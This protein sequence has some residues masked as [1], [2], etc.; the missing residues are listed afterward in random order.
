MSGIEV[1]FPA[2]GVSRRL[3]VTVGHALDG[4]AHVAECTCCSSVAFAQF[5]HMTE[6]PMSVPSY[7]A[8]LQALLGIAMDVMAG[9]KAL[10][11][12]GLVHCDIN[13]RNVLLSNSMVGVHGYP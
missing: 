1:D 8:V 9:I 13:L 6:M 5:Q 7:R 10:H 12:E 3:P 4:T 11:A 2:P